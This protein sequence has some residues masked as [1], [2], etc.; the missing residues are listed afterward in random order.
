MPS[1]W[2]ALIQSVEGPNRTK[3][4]PLMNKR[5]LLLPKFLELGYSSF[6]AFG[7]ELKYQLFLGVEPSD[8]QT[9]KI[10]SALLGLQLVYYRS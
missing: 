1:V 8:F 4:D 5:E 3:L 2:L 7:L 6:L 9:E 10:L